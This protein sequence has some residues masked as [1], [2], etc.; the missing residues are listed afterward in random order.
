MYRFI[1]KRGKLLLVKLKRLM[2]LPIL[3]AIEALLLKVLFSM[4]P[5][6]VSLVVVPLLRPLRPSVV[7]FLPV[8]S[9][10]FCLVTRLQKVQL[11]SR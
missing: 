8:G 9:C 11:G 5:I 7:E 10:F 2:R 1:R 6:T 3:I 4:V